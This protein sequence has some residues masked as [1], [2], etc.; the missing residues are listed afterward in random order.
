MKRRAS[1]SLMKHSPYRLET[2]NGFPLRTSGCSRPALFQLFYSGHSKFSTLFIKSQI[3]IFEEGPQRMEINL[4]TLFLKLFGPRIAFHPWLLSL[5]KACHFRQGI[6]Q[7]FFLVDC[8]STFCRT[9]RPYLFLKT[10]QYFQVHQK[11][12][13]TNY[14][15]QCALLKFVYFIILLDNHQGH[16]P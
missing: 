5:W 11:R 6:P 13:T 2:M 4:C 7:W 1:S 14:W 15:D 12:T 8:S 3:L 9:M 16:F 10:W